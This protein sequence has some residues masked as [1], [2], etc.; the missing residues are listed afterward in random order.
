MRM[1]RLGTRKLCHVLSSD[2]KCISVGRDKLF[3]I[4]GANQLLIKPLRSYQ[5][6]TNSHHHFRKHKNL[7]E[8]LPVVRPE[9]VWV[10]DITYVGSR[11]R[12]A[13]LALITDAYSKKI[14]GYSVSAHLDAS[15]CVRALKMATA[16]RMYR[17]KSL[18]HHS[19]RGIQYCCG[20][21]QSALKRK[22]ILCSMTEC[23]DP[24]QNAVAER[25]NG[26]LKQEFMV[27]NQQVDI[28]TLSRIVKESVAIYN[29]ER[30]H[31]SCLMLTPA[32][33]HKQQRLTMK[34][35]HKEKSTA[36]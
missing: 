21:Y 27:D 29:N 7:V 20:M 31:Y 16:G 24:Y 19:D 34:T 13:Y 4:L 15:N 33:M 5:V 10:S 2:L 17:D 36:A 32:Q 22:K 23:Y 25:V 35:Y 18:I 3:R 11:E 30:P 28:K 1:P 12:Q 6:T 14:M 9:Q 8:K 26:I